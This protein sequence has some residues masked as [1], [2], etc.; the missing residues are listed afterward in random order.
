MISCSH[1]GMFCAS[2]AAVNE[3]CSNYEMFLGSLY[4]NF[5]RG[6]DSNYLHG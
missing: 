5:D 1:W 4:Q 2:D 6:Y 3:I